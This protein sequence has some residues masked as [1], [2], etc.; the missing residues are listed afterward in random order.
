[1]KDKFKIG[2]KVSHAFVVTYDDLA[3]F[4][5]GLVHEVCSTYR[6][7]KEMEWVGRLFVLEMKEE[8]EEG[9]GTMIELQHVSPAFEGDEVVFEATYQ[10]F[11][12]NELICDMEARVG[13]RVIATGKT[14][15][16]II[17]KEKIEK[18][19]RQTHSGS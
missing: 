12:D 2:D 18:L 14:G 5:A 19:F 7:T 4:D 17:A 11:V 10:G 9:V 13:D 6:L 3:H 15:Q 16:K 1:M 8:H